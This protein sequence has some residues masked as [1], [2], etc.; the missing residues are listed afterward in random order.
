MLGVLM[1]W[2]SPKHRGLLC[3]FALS[4]G[5]VRWGRELAAKGRKERRRK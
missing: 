3:L 1:G 5:Q 2:R 4:K